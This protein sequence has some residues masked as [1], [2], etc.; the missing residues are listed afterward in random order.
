[1]ITNA[2]DLLLEKKNLSAEIT[3]S[4]AREIMNGKVNDVSI[5]AFLTALRMKGETPDEIASFVRIM[6]E[7]C[8]RI[9]PNVQGVLIDTCGTGGDN[10]NT[11]NISTAAAFVAAGAG[12]PVAKHG[13]RSISSNCGSA[14]IL[15][16]MEVN[17][18][19]SGTQVKEIIEKIGIGFMFAPNFHPAM[20]HVQPVRKKLAIRTI[21]NILGPLTNPASVQ[22][23]VIGV[24][25]RQLSEKIALALKQVGLQHIL[26]VNGNKMDEISTIGKTNIIEVKKGKMIKYTISPEEFG[27]QKPNI[28]HIVSTNIKTSVDCFKEVLEGKKGP[29]LDIVLINSAAA[30]VVGEKAKNFQDGFDLSKR[31]IQSGKALEKFNQFREESIQYET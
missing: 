15:E 19:L 25:D 21:F 20:K 16:A 10:M 24:Y 30:L 29:R 23:Q 13:N 12:I 9:S 6:R 11:F 26:V 5:A 18:N 14:D 22:A 8:N 2:I 7:F 28:K 1:M 31:V 4:V 27:I 3:E 17:I